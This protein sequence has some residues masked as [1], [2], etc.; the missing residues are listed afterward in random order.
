MHTLIIAAIVFA[1]GLTTGTIWGRAMEQ[2]AVIKVLGE[3][4]KVDDEARS[5]VNRL[6][7]SLPYLKKHL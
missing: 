1:A 3:F 5:A 6:M 2:A 4:R 7:N